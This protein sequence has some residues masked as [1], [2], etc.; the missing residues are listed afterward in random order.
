MAKKHSTERL[1]EITFTYIGTDQAFDE[2]LKRLIQDYLAVDL[3][4]S[5]GTQN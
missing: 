1:D 5:E 3:S 4:H 2:F